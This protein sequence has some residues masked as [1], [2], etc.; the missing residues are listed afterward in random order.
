[1]PQHPVT[2]CLG[3][4]ELNAVSRQHLTMDYSKVVVTLLANK[5]HD[6][7]IGKKNLFKLLIIKYLRLLILSE[8]RMQEQLFGGL[9]FI[10]F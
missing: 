9:E 6:D 8:H 10:T 2:S 4:A 3:L 1:M 5:A 7:Q